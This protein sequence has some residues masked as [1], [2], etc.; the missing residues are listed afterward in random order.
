M[1]GHGRK[2]GQQDEPKPAFSLQ[3]GRSSKSGFA[4]C[5]VVLHILIT[6]LCLGGVQGFAGFCV[7]GENLGFI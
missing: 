4:D 7:Q 5:M 6:C 2:G 3:K 1:S